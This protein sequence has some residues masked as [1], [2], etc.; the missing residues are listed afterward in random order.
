VGEWHKR[1]APVTIRFQRALYWRGHVAEVPFYNR[2]TDIANT[3][4]AIGEENRLGGDTAKLSE[5]RRSVVSIKARRSPLSYCL[6]EIVRTRCADV[7]V[8]LRHNSSA[9]LLA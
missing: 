9:D 8:Y 4:A 2:S 3:G 5:E 1:V 7:V 6:A